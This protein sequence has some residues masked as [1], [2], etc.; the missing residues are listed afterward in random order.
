MSAFRQK[1]AILTDIWH[2][3]F[4]AEVKR[5]AISFFVIYFLLLIVCL[6]FPDLRLTLMEYITRM[7][8]TF[9]FT[10]SSSRSMDA[11]FFNN[12]QAC[13]FTVFY[14]LLPFLHYSAFSLGM[15]ASLLGVLA[16]D[17]LASGSSLAVYLLGTVPHSIFELTALVFACAMGLY[18]CGHMTRRFKHDNTAMSLWDCMSVMSWLV[19]L[20]LMP[21]LLISSA[22]EVYVTPLLL[23]FVI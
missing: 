14:G 12:I 21:L 5:T 15:N 17:H 7:F 2:K 22:V 10:T 1:F 8:G 11:L 18:A 23:S 13:T 9:E 16:A 3:G 19:L 4:D 20:V 6:L